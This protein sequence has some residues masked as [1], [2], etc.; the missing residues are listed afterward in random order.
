MQNTTLV[1]MYFQKVT[2]VI[3]ICISERCFTKK[4]NRG[5][6]LAKTSHCLKRKTCTP[7]VYDYHIVILGTT[8]N[9]NVGRGNVSTKQV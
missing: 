6:V 4:P 8:L 2:V 7:I 3:P 1:Y 5:Q 9:T